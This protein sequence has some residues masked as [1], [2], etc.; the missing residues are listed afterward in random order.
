MKIT[1]KGP[2]TGPKLGL[3]RYRSARSAAFAAS[4]V[5]LVAAVPAV[6][7]NVVVVMD[8]IASESTL[9]WETEGAFILPSMQGLVGNDPQTGL[10]DNS[11]LAESWEHNEDFT[12]WTFR[13]KPDARFHGDWGSVTSADVVHS[14]GLHV[15]PD[16]RLSGIGALRDATVTAVD[17][18]TVRFDLPAPQSNFLFLMAGRGVLV[19]YSKAQFDDEG[20]DGYRAK[21]AGTGPFEFAGVQIGQ[22][23]DFTAVADHWGGQSP[24]YDSLSIKFAGEAATKLSM[25]LAK[26]ADIVSLPRELQPQALGQGFQIVASTQ[27]ANQTALAFGSL[28]FDPEGGDTSLELPWKDA[29]VREA[30]NRALNRDEMIDVLYAGRAEKL[31][32]FTMDEQ[33]EGYSAELSAK[34]EESY[35]YD[36][37]R[38]RALLAEAG[39]PDAFADPVVPIIVTN[40]PG[41]PEFPLLSELV[42][43]YWEAVGIQTELREMDQ[44]SILAARRER[45]APWIM[46]V[47]NAPIRPAQLGLQVYFSY[48]NRP[49]AYLDDPEVNKLFADLAES[50]DMEERD[51]LASQIFTD[52]FTNYTH[53]PIA[54]IFAEVTVNPATIE[55]WTFPGSTSS[56]LSHFHLISTK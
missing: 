13:L 9:Y 14:V 41:N 23:M 48:V 39:Y 30:M 37:D 55:G 53:A 43:G 2:A 1:S 47:R 38:A 49:T 10:Y 33:F 32:I 18:L 7:Q 19:I 31:P 11:A 35:G 3:G 44:A 21:P 5:A 12:S 56:G 54:K 25:L 36:P 15:S 16:S 8:P 50:V 27:G 34:F 24:D 52:L 42:Q 26:E 28:F 46:P 4:L 40:L 22:G 6:A 17:D 45:N 20:V 51:R 29:R